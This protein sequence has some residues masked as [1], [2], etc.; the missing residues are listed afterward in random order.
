[1]LL[2]QLWLSNVGLYGGDQTLEFSR[3]RS[4]P[5]TLIGGKNGTGKTSLLTAIPLLLYGNRAKSII[6]ASAYPEHLNR[7]V[8]S[9]GYSAS[10]TLEFDRRESG[11]LARYVV[12]RHW[13]RSV[14]GKATDTLHVDVNDKPR[15]DLE[16]IWPEFVERIMPLSVS[17]LAIFDGEKIEAL[18]DV[19]NSAE[20]LRTSLYGLLGLDLVQRLQRD[21]TEYRRKAAHALPPN[22]KSIGPSLREAED[23]LGVALDELEAVQTELRIAEHSLEAAEGDFAL[24]NENLEAAGGSRA[25]AREQMRA[26]LAAAESSTEA[27]LRRLESMIAGDLPL[28]LVRPLLDDVIAMGERSQK[29]AEAQ[30]LLVRMKE[31]DERL[32]NELCKH[33]ETFSEGATSVFEQLLSLDRQRYDLGYVGGFEVHDA[34]MSLARHLAAEHGDDLAEEAAGLVAAMNE[35][36]VIALL[37]RQSLESIPTGDAFAE[38]VRAVAESETKVRTASA[39]VAVAQERVADR[40]RRVVAAQREVDRLAAEVLEAGVGDADSA[41]ISREID[42]AEETL[43]SFSARIVERHLGRITENITRSLRALLRKEGLVSRLVIDPATLGISLFGRRGNLLDPATLSACE[44][45]MLATAVLWGLS[46]STGRMLPTVIDTPVG[47]LDRSHRTNLV[48][49][50]FPS[51]ARQVIL[52]STDEE[53]VGNYLTQLG[54][55]VGKSYLLDYDDEAEATSIKQGYFV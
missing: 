24:A 38:I 1:M 9:G 47:R 5:V 37:A 55:H 16:A 54:P 29:A 43:A 42:R 14:N 12:E 20:V 28:L 45:Q 2:R 7:L 46:R 8:H 36:T 6:G 50:Y 34:A 22:Q 30:L 51:A 19:T 17:G 21:L 26:E 39:Q 49:R 13:S 53:I 44:R 25:A 10:I 40:D 52:L 18:A 41:R 48:S 23:R 11:K 3:D 33:P 31:R 32:L 4:R 15:D 27:A 35:G